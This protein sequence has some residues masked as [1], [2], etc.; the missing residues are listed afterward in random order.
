MVAHSA[1]LVQVSRLNLSLLVGSLAVSAAQDQG[2][3]WGTH[4]PISSWALFLGLSGSDPGFGTPGSGSASQ[5]QK[6]L[7]MRT[8]RYY[9]EW[10]GSFYS[11]FCISNPVSLHFRPLFRST[12]SSLNFNASLSNPLLCNSQAQFAYTSELLRPL[13]ALIWDC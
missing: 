1:F 13:F 3:E 2:Q 6:A 4:G 7:T 12:F 10:P 9:N 11:I 5:T 8:A